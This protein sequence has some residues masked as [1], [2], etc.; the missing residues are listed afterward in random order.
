MPDFIALHDPVEACWR[1]SHDTSMRGTI[2]LADGTSA[3][4]LELQWQ[5]HEWLS[6]YA[7]QSGG[8]HGDLLTEWAAILT[9]LE[10]DPLST[11]DRLDWAAK[12]R[13]LEGMR[14]RHGLAWDDPKLKALA[15]QYHDIDPQRGIYHRL[16]R[17]GELRRLFAD[18]EI[19]R[20]T[21]R[22]PEETR[23]YFRGECV[24]RY[25]ESLVAANW[26]SLVFDT[27]EGSLKRVPMM[28][29]LRGGKDRVAGLL[30]GSPTAA[31]LLE[32]LGG[33]DGRAGTEET[34]GPR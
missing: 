27:G 10:E 12:Y 5:Y 29:P 28:E 7:E 3:T 30:D 17:R 18:E 32:T 24:A 26:D 22:P 34:P 14:E 9:D 13:L 1:V 23:A 16:L 2:S 25:P 33:S 4:A 31:G 6:K 8:D 19:D 15:L 11:A 21:R 20:A